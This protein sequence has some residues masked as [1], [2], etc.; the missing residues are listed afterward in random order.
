MPLSQ[1]ILSRLVDHQSILFKVAF[2]G[3][4]NARN[5][6][7]TLTQVINFI[8]VPFAHHFIKIFDNY[9]AKTFTENWVGKQSFFVLILTTT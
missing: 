5:F 8:K 2:I 7:S 9:T 1:K 6:L 4:I 3:F